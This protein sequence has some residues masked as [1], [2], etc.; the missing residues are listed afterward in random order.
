MQLIENIYLQGN[1]K[2]AVLLLHS[3][4]SNAKEMQ[5]LAKAL[6]QDG[7]T[8]YAP[9]LDGHGATPEQLFASSI[10]K[11]AA[12]SKEA[13][14]FLIEKKYETIYV[15]GQSLGGVLSIRLAN[16]FPQIK[17]ICIISSP[18]LERP[19]EE[20][21]KRVAQFSMRY[22]KNN[23]RTEEGIQDFMHE[24]FPRPVKKFIAFQQ[25]IVQTGKEVHTIKQPLFLA[26]G[27]LDEG[28]F[29]KSIDLIEQ[30]VNGNIVCKK[31]YEKSG[32]LISLGKERE[33]LAEDILKFLKQIEK[34]TVSS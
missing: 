19:P 10:E 31:L 23:G 17:A 24:H 28:V 14:K 15:I 8:C 32:H 21:E 29:H 26:K 11:V 1:E 18:V 25:F 3:F 9:N 13:V 34:R 5:Y 7:Y 4:T 22:L 16:E 20:L 30:S 6:H 2:K 12:C 27:G 33:L